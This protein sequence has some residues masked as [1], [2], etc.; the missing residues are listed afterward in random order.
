[1]RPLYLNMSAFGPYAGKVELDME[2]L[3]EQGL[4]AITGETGAGKTTI[5]D[6]IMFALYNRGSGADR[7]EPK[8]LRSKYAD[9]TTETSVT[10]TFEHRGQQYTVTRSPEQTV[11]GSRRSLVTK[12]HTAVLSCPDDVTY[13]GPKNVDAKIV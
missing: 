1:M 8:N 10:L 2:Q 7:K 4:Y 9:E 5:F 6:A 3:G 12:V 11:I 13:T